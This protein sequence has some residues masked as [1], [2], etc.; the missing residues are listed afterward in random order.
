[1]AEIRFFPSSSKGWHGDFLGCYCCSFSSFS[2]LWLWKVP[3]IRHCKE[4][5]TTLFLVFH[6]FKGKFPPQRHVE[7]ILGA[8]LMEMGKNNSNCSFNNLCPVQFLLVLRTDFIPMLWYLWHFAYF[9]LT[10]LNGINQ[11]TL[12]VLSQS[13]HRLIL[14]HFISS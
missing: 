7:P 11:A 1:M 4:G 12:A 10:F 14:F 13:V 8:T 9:L 6:F 3:R 5:D 2:V